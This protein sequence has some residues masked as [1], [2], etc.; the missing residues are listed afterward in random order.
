MPVRKI[1]SALGHP[2]GLVFLSLTEAW[3]RFSFYGMQTLLVLYMVDT[4][5]RPDH[6]AAVVGLAALRRQ[7]E[8]VFGPMPNPA[9]ASAIFGLYSGLVYFTPI[10]GGLIGDRWLGQ[11]RTVTLGAVLLTIGQIM[12]AFEQPFL[13][14]IGFLILGCGCLKGN[15]SAQ[16]GRL[17]GENDTR[18]SNA[19]AIYNV[20]INIGAL[21]GP[22]ICGAVGAIYGWR[23]GFAVAGGLMV[24]GLI[25]YLAG[26]NL[27]PPD[28]MRPAGT[29]RRTADHKEIR[30]VTAL[31]AMLILGM[32]FT[33]AY[34]QIGDMYTL[35]VRDNVDRHFLGVELPAPWFGAVDSLFTIVSTPF[36]L[37]LWHRQ[38]KRNRE[39][40]AMTKIAIGMI[41]VALAYGMLAVITSYHAHVHFVW[42]LLFSAIMGTAFVHQW[43]TTLALISQY[44]PARLNSTMMG[45]AFLSMFV[46]YSVIGW[47][48]GFYGKVPLPTFWLIQT[49]LAAAGAVLFLVT[50]SFFM[51]R[52]R[53]G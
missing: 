36:L 2:P 40:S 34:Y 10:F 17:Y 47:I 46:S 5:L 16:V 38:A 28:A 51:R 33:I 49:A 15:I 29:E 13:I 31:L 41:L 45:V 4:L 7:M 3:E 27:L 42:C 8:S 23:Y 39:P 14:A 21:A 6:V 44:A 50:G 11:R 18:R 35:W 9:F 52:F 1:A 20:G 26:W 19:Y 22:F 12:M 53:G 30:V 25:T 24:L 37:A 32:L 48:G 43:P